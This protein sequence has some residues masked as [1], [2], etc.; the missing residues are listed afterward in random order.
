MEFIDEFNEILS[1][2]LD[3]DSLEAISNAPADDVFEL[4]ETL[5]HSSRYHFQPDSTP[6]RNF[7]FIANS[8]LSGGRHPC[9]YSECRIKKLDELVS[10]SSLYADEVYIQNPFEEIL[11]SGPES[12]NYISRQELIYGIYNY[13]YLKPLIEKGIIKYAQN[14]VSLCQHHSDTLAKPI[15]AEIIKKENRLYGLLENQLAERCTISFDIGKGA[16]PFLKFEGPHGLIDH[17]VIYLHLSGEL[18]ESIA[19]LIDKKLPYIFSRTEVLSEGMLSLI[20]APIIKDLSNQEWHSAFYGTSY[21]CDNPAQMK[22]AAKLNS[23]AYAAS[24]SAFN[25]GMSHSL[26]SVYAKDLSA[27]VKLR[28]N[29]GEAFAVYRDK[30]HSLLKSTNRWS[31]HEVAEAF[32]DQ[33]LP[34]VNLID[35]KIKDWKVKARESLKEKVIFGTGAVSIGL[36]AGML[37]PNIGQLVAA[38]GGGSAIAGAVLDYNKTLKDKIEARS[39]DFYFLWQANQ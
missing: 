12:I 2:W 32:R 17:G 19:R 18:P 9:S 4:A 35:K 26:P 5:A 1:L 27:I 13:F 37:P 31:E 38:I 15:S 22:I 24:S 39:N 33:I 16:G 8:S 3:G 36:Y 30:I 14:M 23:E 20:I 10:F 28:E 25:K 21:L 7:S 29:E 34:E 11:I 6:N